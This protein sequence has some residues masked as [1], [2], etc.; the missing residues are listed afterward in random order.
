MINSADFGR[1]L[2]QIL[3]SDHKA[4][5]FNGLEVKSYII[6]SILRVAKVS[7]LTEA[8]PSNAQNGHHSHIEQFSTIA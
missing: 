8:I 7:G 5:D 4:R 1:F 2:V 3:Q 6:L